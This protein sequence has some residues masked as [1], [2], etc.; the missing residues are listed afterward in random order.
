MKASDLK[1]RAVVVLSDA[2]K[3]GHVDDLLFDAQYREVLGLRVKKGGLLSESEALLRSN[4]A[5]V[6]ADAVTVPSPDVINAENRFQELTG[7]ATLT[8]A[9]GTRI[10]TEGGTLLGTVS[11]VELDE[12]VSKV[13]AYLLNA[14]LLDRIRGHI[15][16]VAAQ[17]VLRL[18]EG[19][20]MIVSD[21][22][23]EAIKA[24]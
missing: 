2:V 4:V 17:D 1:G 24:P 18:G 5:S 9:Q 13:T 15:P 21:S 7:A 19:G 11:D 8:Q 12:Q 20:I 10:V 3:V 14:P 16:Q 6:G 23:A 22:T